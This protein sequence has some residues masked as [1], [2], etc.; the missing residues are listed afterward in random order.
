VSDSVENRGSLTF[1]VRLWRETD[2]EGH[3]HWRGRV[4]QVASQ[5]VGYVENVAGVALFIERWT[6]EPATAPSVTTG[7]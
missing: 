4:E 2:A 5:E 1:V 6:R 3:A 7:G